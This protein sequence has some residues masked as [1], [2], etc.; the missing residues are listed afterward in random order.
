MMSEPSTS[1]ADNIMDEGAM[2]YVFVGAILSIHI[3]IFV[4]SNTLHLYNKNIQLVL[5]ERAASQGS[6]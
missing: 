4:S 1:I 3:C 2:K 5:N 6:K